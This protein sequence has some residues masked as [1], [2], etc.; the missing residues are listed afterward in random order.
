MTDLKKVLKSLV[1]SIVLSAW[2]RFWAKKRRA[3][4]D[5]CHSPQDTFTAIYRRGDWGR[6]HDRPDAFFSGFGSHD[7][8][9]VRPYVQAMEAFLTSYNPHLDVADLGCGDFAVG[10]QIRRYCGKY[11]ACDV[12]Q[13]V[14][15]QH[16]IKY[17]DHDVIFQVVDITKD[18]LPRADV[19]LLRQVLQHLSNDDIGRV[20]P[21]LYQYRYIVFT[22]HLPVVEDFEPNL[23]KRRGMD[24]RLTLGEKGSGVVLIEPPFGLKVKSA[25]ILCEADAA[26]GGVPGVVRTIL[27]DL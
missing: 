26:I 16:K 17:A 13:D 7:P 2:Y 4:L 9:I 11:Y 25:K 5:R 20:V 3:E 12:V 14:I 10:A 8:K 23:D 1:P 18:G 15:D 21:K 24:T 27:Y 22:E 6:S 19:A